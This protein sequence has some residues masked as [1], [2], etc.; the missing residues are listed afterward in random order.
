M[1]S[2][3]ASS[4]SESDAQ[5]E[6]ISITSQQS[7]ESSRWLNNTYGTEYEKS[8]HSQATDAKGSSTENHGKPRMKLV[9][10][11][12]P[13]SASLLVYKQVDTIE[14]EDS[15][16]PAKRRRQSG[17][18]RPSV[19]SFNTWQ[20]VKTELVKPK[21]EPDVARYQCLGSY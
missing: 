19:E 2:A 14:S 7:S 1:L 3:N 6:S 5:I 21:E 10:V 16:M 4:S 8:H 15:L 9:G 17:K 20:A 12:R 18:E 13:T 11:G